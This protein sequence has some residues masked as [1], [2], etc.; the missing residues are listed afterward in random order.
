MQQAVWQKYS[1]DINL[2][3][4]VD[5]NDFALLASAWGSHFGQQG[6]IMRCDLSAVTD[7]EIGYDDLVCLSEQWLCV[8]KWRSEYGE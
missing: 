6:W 7:L 2:D 4:I 5:E 8:E 3:G 1:A